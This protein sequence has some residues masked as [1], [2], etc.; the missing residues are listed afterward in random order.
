MEGRL[1]QRKTSKRA[2]PTSIY[3]RGKNK[4]EI[5][6]RKTF[7]ENL[8]NFDEITQ[9]LWLC[10]SSSPEVFLRKGVLKVCGKFTGEHPCRSAISIKLQSNFIE[11]TL[12]HGCSPVNLL[13]IFRTPFVKSTFGWLFAILIVSTLRI[14]QKYPPVTNYVAIISLNPPDDW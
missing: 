14:P 7:T 9:Q 1:W 2:L 8:N 5:F 13:H 10:R 3:V 11:I 12:R 4:T 6:I